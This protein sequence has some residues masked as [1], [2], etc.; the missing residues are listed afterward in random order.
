MTKKLKFDSFKKTKLLTLMMSV[1]TSKENALRELR[2]RPRW[3]GGRVSTMGLKVPGSKPD[4]TEDPS[5]TEPVARQP[6]DPHTAPNR[7]I[8]HRP[9][10]GGFGACVNFTGEN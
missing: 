9:E 7:L 3:P 1:Q 5:C 10:S 2:R 8:R 4:S 6:S